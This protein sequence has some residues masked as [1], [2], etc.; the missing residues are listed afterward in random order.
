MLARHLQLGG[1]ALEL[2]EEPRVD[3]GERRLA[4]ECLEQ[5]DVSSEKPPVVFRRTT[6]APTIRPSRSIG[7]A[8][9]DRQPSS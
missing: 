5:V 1:L 2:A 3:D 8:S 4:G 6:S 7:T 9:T